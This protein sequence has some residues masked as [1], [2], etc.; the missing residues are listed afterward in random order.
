MPK[1]TSCRIPPVL[2]WVNELHIESEKLSKLVYAS[3]V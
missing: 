1:A 3:I 2:L